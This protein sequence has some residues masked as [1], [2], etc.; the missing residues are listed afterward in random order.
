MSRL[1]ACP[2][3]AVLIANSR[4]LVLLCQVYLNFPNRVV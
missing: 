4:H 1:Y 2:G 3:A